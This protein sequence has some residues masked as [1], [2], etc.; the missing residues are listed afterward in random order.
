MP[1]SKHSPSH[2]EQ[3]RVTDSLCCRHS[4]NGTSRFGGRDPRQAYDNETR[5]TSPQD[6]RS[7]ISSEEGDVEIGQATVAVGKGQRASV[8]DMHQIGYN[9]SPPRES[10]L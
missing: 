4:V 5:P 10:P 9:G 3:R 8:I 2:S 6:D 1:L 7:D